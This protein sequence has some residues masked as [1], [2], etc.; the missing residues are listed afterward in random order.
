MHTIYHTLAPSRTTSLPHTIERMLD[1]WQAEEQLGWRLDAWLLKYARCFDE[2]DR[3]QVT[4]ARRVY[5]LARA[6]LQ[7]MIS[8]HGRAVVRIPFVCGENDLR[9]LSSSLRQVQ[10]LHRDLTRIHYR[11]SAALDESRKARD[12]A[13]VKVLSDLLDA[14]EQTEAMLRDLFDAEQSNNREAPVAIPA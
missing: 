2:L 5:G 9:G 13:A 4:A 8:Q 7:Q 6:G 10:Y 1:L 3:E 14:H 12:Y 11:T